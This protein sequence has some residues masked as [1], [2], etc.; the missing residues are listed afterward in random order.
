MQPCSPISIIIVTYNVVR[1]LEETISSILTVGYPNYKLIIIDGGST[2]GTVA[3]I[4]KYS[5]SISYWVS[6]PDNGIYHAM[7]KGWAQADKESH[8]L[9]LGA[10]DHILSLPAK[11]PLKKECIY[12]GDV[13]I[14]SSFT[15]KSSADWRLKIG[16]TLHH[17]SLLIPKRLHLDPPFNDLYKVYGDFD[18]NQRLYAAGTCFIRSNEISSYAL[19][20][21]ISQ[22]LETFEWL[23]IIKKNFGPLY[24]GIGY[25][26][27]YYHKI[28]GV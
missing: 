4:E 23:S 18:F 9:Y 15:F 11:T 7:N 17:Q 5:S 12:Y 21:G 20:D 13:K 10:G 27:F 2:D 16:N 28:K 25:L 22:R 1:L 14:T 24:A 3:L 26:F 8:I 19:P 6:E